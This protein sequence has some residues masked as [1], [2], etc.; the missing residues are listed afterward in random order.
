MFEGLYLIGGFV[1]GSFTVFL[2][3]LYSDIKF[4]KLMRSKI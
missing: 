1:G 2:F 4:T 3:W